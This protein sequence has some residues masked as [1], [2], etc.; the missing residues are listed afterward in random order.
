MKEELT[1]LMGLKRTKARARP[2]CTGNQEVWALIRMRL[3]AK[4][5]AFLSLTLHFCIIKGLTYVVL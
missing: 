5:L 3:Q 1:V 2:R 4:S